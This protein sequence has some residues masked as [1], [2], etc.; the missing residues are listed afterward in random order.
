[1]FYPFFVQFKIQ[2]GCVVQTPNHFQHVVFSWGQLALAGSAD[3]YEYSVT[4]FSLYF[5]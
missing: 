5:E 1:M 3:I 4:S 2:Q